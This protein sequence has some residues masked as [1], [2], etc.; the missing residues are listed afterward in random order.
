MIRGVGLRSAVAIN[1]ATMVGAGPFI[2]LPLVVTALHGSV[3]AL[4]WVV[5]ALIAL[6]DGLVWAEL[7]SRYPRS[8][9]TYTYL[10]EGFGAHG[11]GRFV[12]FL[13]VWQ[14]LFWAPLIL[15]TGYI[16]FAQYAAYLVPALG[17]F[18]PTH[19]LAAA[20]GLVTLIALYRAIPQIARTALVLGGVALAT[21]LVVAFAGLTHPYAPLAGTVA[22]TFTLGV[23]IAPLGKALIQTVYDYGG[24]GDVCALGDEVIAPARTIP[25]AILISIALV[26]AAYILLNLGVAAAVAPADIAKSSAIASLVAQRAFGAPFAAVVT[27]AV[28]LTAFAST[29]GLLLAASRVPYAAAL[30]GDF[31][32][33]FARLHAS[34]KFP[35]VSLVAIGLLALPASLLPLDAVINALTAGIVLIQGAGQI[36]AL[37]LARRTRRDAPFRVPLYPLPPLI[38]LAGWLYLFW[39]TDSSSRIFGIVTLVVGALVYFV[40]ARIVRGWPFGVSTLASLIA[41][42]CVALPHAAGAQPRPPAPATT[43]SFGHA[44]IVRDARDEPVLRL[45]GKPFF[46]LGGAFFYERI[47]RSQWRASMMQMRDLGANTLDLY[48]PWNWHELADGD[49]DFDGRTS[50]RRDLREVLRLG[51]ELGFFFIVRPGPV[52]RNEWR[53][54]G[55]PAWLLTRPEYAMEQHDV[56][57][58]RYPATATLQNKQSDDAAAEWLHNAMH[59][60]YAGRWLHRAL[61]EFRPVADRVIAVQLD[62]DQGAYLDNDT[63]PGPHF[64]AYL[65]WLETQVREVVGPRTPAF[66]NTFETKVPSSLPVW[67]MGNW[68]QSDANAIGEHD[69]AELAFATATLRTQTRGPL[70]VSE[71]Q[72]GWL[73]DPADP[74]PRAADPSNTTLALGELAGWGLKGLIDFPLQDTLAP[75]GWEAPFSNALYA[76]DAAFMLDR[77]FG[78]RFRETDVQFQQLALYGPA[79]AEAHRIADIA[80]LYDGRHDAYRAAALLKAGLADCRTRGIT[81]DAIDPATVTDRRLSSFRYLVVPRGEYRALV[82]R[83]ER[84]HVRV[85]PSPGAASGIRSTPGATLLRSPHG[86]FVVVENWSDRDLRYDARDLP[87]A[88]RPIPPFALRAREAR[89]IA[90]DVDLAFLSS[91]Y[92]RGDRLTSSCAV[93]SY[94]ADRRVY[95]GGA[96]PAAVAVRHRDGPTCE[97]E[98]TLRGRHEH[99][100]VDDRHGAALLPGAAL[101]DVAMLVS[102]DHFSDPGLRLSRFARFPKPR[103]DVTLPAGAHAYRS[104]VFED[105][106]QDVVLQ[107]ARVVAVAVP[108]GGARV[109][110]FGRYLLQPTANTPSFHNVFDATGGVRDDVLQQLPPSTTDRIA[111]YTHLYPAGMFNRPYD[112]CTFESARG[113]GAY[114]AYDAP[115]VVPNGA[116]F[117]RVLALSAASDRLV[118]DER[119]VPSAPGEQQ[120]LVSL[121]ALAALWPGD[122]GGTAVVAGAS[123]TPFEREV[124]LDPRFGGVT[125]ELGFD[126][127]GADMIAVSWPL[128]DVEAASWKPAQSNGTL[129]LVLAP[130]A[131]R[132]VTYAAGRPETA[133][134]RRRFGEAERAW[135][136]ANPAPASESGEV[137]KRYTQSPQ[138]RPSESSCGFESH[139]P[140]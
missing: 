139:L 65:R 88:G 60:R 23:G 110:S 98:A 115:D 122:P 107:N 54:G 35:A 51:K 18:V 7:A 28:M 36:V 81:C 61:A 99:W 69:R 87:D 41:L 39:S 25:R 42:A 123:R 112:A 59:L 111:K 91:L 29:Y 67:A 63:F 100:N 17:G 121:S 86:T 72:A 84:L 120:R 128:G 55:Y 102:A 92:A 101:Q 127:P 5:G 34:G 85:I 26:C 106:A 124:S 117:E 3:S 114:F 80:V 52:I 9:G 48:V 78:S 22:M 24:Y 103:I 140:Q 40:R 30:D 136:A 64:H 74:Q 129:R 126:G 79:L 82:A 21:L 11:P 33:P 75:F 38:A 135:A 44:L 46:F 27:L 116:R 94:G 132:R 76:W 68:Y 130:G 118:V 1:V 125:L 62:D 56:L 138:K 12:A 43:P 37:A 45:D 109:V 104:D 14:F 20:V 4:A 113:A 77:G 10:R 96:E 6:C 58:G 57:E 89:I 137:A 71:F 50:P 97:V 93:H 66:I 70:A 133:D 53:N 95:F 31:L 49:F 73:A 83:A 15:A 90:V 108:D 134:E 131:W 16:G 19:L 105:G 32:A 47:P 13:F 2:T 119:F 8:G